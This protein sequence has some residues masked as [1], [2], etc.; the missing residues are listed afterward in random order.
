MEVH[1][2]NA[3]RQ[4]IQRRLAESE[5]S[6]NQIRRSC[7]VLKAR[8]RADTVSRLCCVWISSATKCELFSTKDVIASLVLGDS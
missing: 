3:L 4:G 2:P 6:E 1:A 5:L 7:R 8:T